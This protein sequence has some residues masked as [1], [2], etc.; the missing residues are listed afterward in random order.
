MSVGEYKFMTQHY[1]GKMFV[2][3]CTAKSVSNL[4]GLYVHI[5]IT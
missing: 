3:I 1:L 2:L 5:C 4:N